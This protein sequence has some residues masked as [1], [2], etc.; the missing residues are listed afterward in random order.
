MGIIS[1]EEHIKV[2]NNIKDLVAEKNI[3]FWKALDLI[4]GEGYDMSKNFYY[5]TIYWKRPFTAYGDFKLLK[6]ETTKEDE[7]V[8]ID[9]AIDRF[10]ASA[11]K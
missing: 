10:T 4:Y 11:V 9:K 1:N 6:G 2:L 3:R 7:D 5:E 8:M